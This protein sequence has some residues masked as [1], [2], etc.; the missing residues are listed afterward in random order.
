[1]WDERNL[2]ERDVPSLLSQL[3]CIEEGLLTKMERGEIEKK[4]RDET[5]K[6][7]NMARTQMVISRE[8]WEELFGESD[9]EE[10]HGFQDFEVERDVNDTERVAGVEKLQSE[11]DFET[12]D[13]DVNKEGIGEV[14]GTGREIKEVVEKMVTFLGDHGLRV[15]SDEEKDVF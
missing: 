8:E 14:R 1:M 4:V 6:I 2:S 9:E 7:D 3:K 11:V 13:D 10:F 5:R 12:D 15:A